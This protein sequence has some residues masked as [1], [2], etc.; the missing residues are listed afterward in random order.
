M[1]DNIKN[2]GPSGQFK[3]Q[4]SAKRDLGVKPGGSSNVAVSETSIGAADE[5]DVQLSSDALKLEGIKK[6]LLSAPDIDEAKVERIKAQ[7]AGGEYKIG[8]ENLA[9]RIINGFANK[10]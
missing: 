8:Y 5:T 4:D 1:I 7:I 9:N 3:T 2:F 6:S 10:G